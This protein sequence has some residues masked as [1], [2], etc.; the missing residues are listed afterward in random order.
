MALRL[1]Y[2]TAM[3]WLDLSASDADRYDDDA[4]TRYF[5]RYAER[6]S[7]PAADAIAAGVRATRVTSVYD[8]LTWSM[9]GS[10][11]GRQAD[12]IAA[13]LQLFTRINRAAGDPAAGLWDITRLVCPVDGSVPA[14]ESVAGI[15]ALL[16]MMMY[17]TAV[18]PD[19]DPTWMFLTTP[20]I[21]KLF[22]MAGVACTIVYA[23]RVSPDDQ[24]DAYLCVAQ[25]RG[26]FARL[27]ESTAPVHRRVFARVQ[28]GYADRE[29][30]AAAVS[31]RG[32]VGVREYAHG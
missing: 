3:G 4:G 2:V 28:A 21:K 16:G 15:Y 13:N 6:T 25:P 23:G 17:E 8:S 9:L 27:R 1:A 20:A 11:A 18:G 24:E 29:R 19:A 31:A 12:I 26:A 32:R 30:C 14:A 7:G 5:L 22:E 10:D